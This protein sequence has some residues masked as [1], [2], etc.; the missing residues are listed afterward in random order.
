[1]PP[2]RTWVGQH[3][4]RVVGAAQQGLSERQRDAQPDVGTVQH[5]QLPGRHGWG[6]GRGGGRRSAELH[7]GSAQ[8]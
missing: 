8:E 1:M 7:D 3:D 5:P 6:G 4:R 2:R